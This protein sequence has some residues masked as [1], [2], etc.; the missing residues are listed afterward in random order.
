MKKQLKGEPIPLAYYGR[1]N[2]PPL[3]TNPPTLASK[4]NRNFYRSLRL[5]GKSHSSIIRMI[6][7]DRVEQFLQDTQFVAEYMDR[8]PKV[9]VSKLSWWSKIKRKIK[10]LF[11]LLLFGGQVM[12]QVPKT[13]IVAVVSAEKD[14]L[15]LANNDVGYMIQEVWDENY[16]NGYYGEE[17]PIIIFKSP[18]WIIRENNIRKEEKEK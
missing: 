17:K 15:Y 4:I 5:K 18:A 16:E 3:N 14:T 2:L 8:T 7:P 12:S 6:Q 1:H 11:I 13:D 9:K 10:L